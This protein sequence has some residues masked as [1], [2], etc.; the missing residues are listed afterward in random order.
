MFVL[1]GFPILAFNVVIITIVR[2]T[3]ESIHCINFPI[4]VTRFSEHYH[5]MKR[6]GQLIIFYTGILN[7][8]ISGI[9]LN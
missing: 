8:P 3:L 1:L 7:K 2:F 9:N 4:D 5:Q 6:L